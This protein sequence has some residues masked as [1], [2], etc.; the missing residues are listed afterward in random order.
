MKEILDIIVWTGII[1]VLA[2][3]IIGFNKQMIDK[4]NERLEN[5]K[6]QED[7]NKND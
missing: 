1:A 2:Y 3:L 6:E 7:D 4:H 5:N